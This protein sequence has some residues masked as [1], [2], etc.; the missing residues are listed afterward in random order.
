MLARDADLLFDALW[1]EHVAEAEVNPVQYLELLHDYAWRLYGLPRSEGG[2]AGEDLDVVVRRFREPYE[3]DWVFAVVGAETG[4]CYG[5]LELSHQ[6][7]IFAGAPL[8]AFGVALHLALNGPARASANRL[9]RMADA[10]HAL[11]GWMMDH[12]EELP[13][14]TVMGAN[15]A[16]PAE[17][18]ELLWRG[19]PG[20]DPFV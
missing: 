8:E 2:R 17:D 10:W 14:T 18:D 20:S 11:V 9:E 19:G 12:A 13:R 3:A 4:R 6:A 5:A 1:A 16:V 15:A 7:P